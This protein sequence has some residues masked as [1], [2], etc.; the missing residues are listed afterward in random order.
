MGYQ[1]TSYFFRTHPV[2]ALNCTVEFL[3]ELSFFKFSSAKNY[4]M[5]C[6]HCEVFGSFFSN[7]VAYYGQEHLQFEGFENS[8]FFTR[9]LGDLG[10]IAGHLY[11]VYSTPLHHALI[12]A[13]KRGGQ[14]KPAN[15]TTNLP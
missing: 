14:L 7:A 3:S 1:M 10:R 8:D 11:S 9:I 13:N 12:H 5:R 6:L 4:A 2:V 15:Q